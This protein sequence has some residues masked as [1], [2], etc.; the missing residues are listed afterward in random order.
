[1]TTADPISLAARRARRAALPAVAVRRV[2][3]PRPPGEKRGAG[4]PADRLAGLATLLAAGPALGDAL[5]EV[6]TL[7]VALTGA[8]HCAVFV[9]GD[10]SLRP[11][12]VAGTD[13][14]A[15]FLALTA[16]RT[17][18][19]L[20]GLLGRDGTVRLDDGGTLPASWQ[21]LF[22]PGETVAVALRAGG[23]AYGLLLTAFDGPAHPA[24]LA[25]LERVACYAALAVRDAELAREQAVRHRLLAQLAE[26]ARALAGASD[27]SAVAGVVAVSFAALLDAP[28]VLVAVS[29]RSAAG[30]ATAVAGAG[31]L[32]GAVTALPEPF[33]AAVARELLGG[34]TGP[35][36]EGFL[37]VPLREGDAVHGA[38]VVTVAG[39]VAPA[40]YA[41]A[42]TVA[43]LAAAALVRIDLQGRLRRQL[44]RVDV[45]YRLSGAI[46]GTDGDRLVGRLNDLLADAGDEVLSVRLRSGRRMT[47][48]A[49][50][51]AA[52][53]ELPMRVG[54]RV[55]G[56]LTAVPAQ[57]DDPDELAFLEAISQGVAEVATRA[58]TRAELE[59]A[60]RDRAV[61]AERE[62]LAADL[63]DSVGQLFV[64]I[65]MLAR[66][67]ADELPADSPWAARFGRLADLSRDGKWA[68]DDAVR[69]LAFVP[70]RRRALVEALR[71]LARSVS[72]DSGIDVVVAAE[73]RSR[74]LPDDV[75]QALF[76]VAHQALAN[77]W[78]HA[79]CGHVAVTVAYEPHAVRVTVT[80]DGT[81]LRRREDGT[82][83]GFGLTTMRR[84]VVQVGGTLHVGDAVP[85]GVTVE[86]RVPVG[87]R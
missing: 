1:M 29:D 16:A 30:V 84:A 73:G 83:T 21:D 41:A 6:A 7:A 59:A 46:E 71:G 60:A 67:S 38:A 36:R 65:T 28:H 54:R 69:A 49:T 47:P 27:P 26:D 22:P 53:V 44:R 12:S 24:G 51:D 64:G 2:P 45:L 85:H 15:P 14:P 32:D 20:R 4:T 74:R 8:R 75:E 81:G 39:G 82:R 77:A 33:R 5:Q 66:R 68:I 62:R 55:V 3:A 40:A 23:A 42:E 35:R 57:P 87:E 19:A 34:G 37:T 50:P 79:R 9:A 58:V 76:R 61:A 48:A 78:R 86:A 18:T 80:D 11:A 43:A 72:S 63:H 52:T 13:D 17:G 56:A 31:P 10:G 70:A 25:L